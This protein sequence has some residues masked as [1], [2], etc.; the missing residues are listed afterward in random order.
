MTREKTLQEKADWYRRNASPQDRLA[1]TAHELG[2]YE[3]AKRA[4]VDPEGIT[5]GHHPVDI[6]SGSGLVNGEIDMGLT[7]SIDQWQQKG[8]SIADANESKKFIISFLKSLYAGEIAEE[9][10][11]GRKTKET[12][13][14][15]SAIHSWSS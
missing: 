7:H 14:K 9:I 2:H 13:I 15:V 12:L 8:L 4:G 1:T 6:K 11:T 5:I 10:V 3:M